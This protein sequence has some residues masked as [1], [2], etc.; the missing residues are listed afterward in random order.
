MQ[1]L[2]KKNSK[3]AKA[4]ELQMSKQHPRITREKKT[5][6]KM[7]HIY[8]KGHHETKGNE[9]CPEC[10]EFLSYAFLRLDNLVW[11]C[12]TRLMDERSLKHWKNSGKKRLKFQPKG[13]LPRPILSVEISN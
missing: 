8:C 12:I 11:R 7:V 10:T 1:R 4:G 6:D 13:A 9:L 5:I 3:S 2:R